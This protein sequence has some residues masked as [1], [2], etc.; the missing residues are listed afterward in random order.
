M[1]WAA[2]PKPGGHAEP[3][4]GGAQVRDQVG[5]WGGL[6]LGTRDHR[7]VGY[8]VPREWGLLTD[9]QRGMGSLAGFKREARAVFLG[10]MG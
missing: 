3:H 4:R 6:H 8:R 1:E 7:S 2:A 5:R 10:G 9:A